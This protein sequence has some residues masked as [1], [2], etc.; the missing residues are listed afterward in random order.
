MPRCQS[1]LEQNVRRETRNA[2]RKKSPQ[3]AKAS[4]RKIR[5]HAHA[6][7]H[8]AIG[9]TCTAKVAAKATAK[10]R[11]FQSAECTVMHSKFESK[12]STRTGDLFGRCATQAMFHFGF[13]IDFFRSRGLVS[14]RFHCSFCAGLYLHINTPRWMYFV[15]VPSYMYICFNKVCR[16]VRFAMQRPISLFAMA[17]QNRHAAVAPFGQ[18]AKPQPMNCAT[19][20]GIGFSFAILGS[21]I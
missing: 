15:H 13:S 11:K 1:M 12:C 4:I 6:V 2:K 17:R 18:V 3:R 16:H 14:F 5:G 7:K 9:S 21:I 8:E 10:A 19:F 20:K